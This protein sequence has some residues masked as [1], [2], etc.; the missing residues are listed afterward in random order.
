[1]I[2]IYI[3]N[4]AIYDNQINALYTLN[5]HNVICQWYLNKSGQ[6]E[7]IGLLWSEKRIFLLKL[8]VSITLKKR[9]KGIQLWFHK[10]MQKT[11]VWTLGWE[12]PLGEGMA[13]YSS[14]LAWRIPWTEEP[15]GLRTIG[16]SRVGQDKQLSMYAQN[17]CDWLCCWMQ[18][19]H[20]WIRSGLGLHETDNI[21]REG[22]IQT[23]K[24][25]VILEDQTWP[26]ALS[27]SQVNGLETGKGFS[28]GLKVPE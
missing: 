3:Y 24:H 15:G 16:S 6:K 27:C 18:G 14:I 19:V 21:E 1:M 2:I 12:D 10:Q 13:T 8:L 22:V 28:A 17:F 25:N 7:D 20:R 23:P 26:V 11:Q 9:L 5:L 4:I